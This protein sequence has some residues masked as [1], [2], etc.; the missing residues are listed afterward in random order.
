MG[1]EYDEWK[2]RDDDDLS[3]FCLPVLS[4][5]PFS[6]SFFFSFPPF[7]FSLL[8]SAG[9]S[10]VSW[11]WLCVTRREVA[12]PTVINIYPIYPDQT[13]LPLSPALSEMRETGEARCPSYSM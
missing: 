9:W 7:S 11:Q 6:F 10:V 12:H 1:R 13:T 4:A 5:F 8:A 2:V 3:P